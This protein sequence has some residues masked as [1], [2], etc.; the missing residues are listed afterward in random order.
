MTITI[1]YMVQLLSGIKQCQHYAGRLRGLTRLSACSFHMLA[2]NRQNT[3]TIL[4]KQM[5]NRLSSPIHRSRYND[6]NLSKCLASK[7]T[8]QIQQTPSD[9]LVIHSDNGGFTQNN[10]TLKVRC[11]SINQSMASFSCFALMLCHTDVCVD[12]YFVG[13]G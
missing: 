10:S 3:E 13:G 5:T 4:L 1:K 12:G 11:T 6:D 8:K 2:Y 7:L 9:P